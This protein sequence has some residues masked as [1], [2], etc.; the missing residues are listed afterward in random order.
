[1]D[2]ANAVRATNQEVGGRLLELTGASFT[3]PAVT[4]GTVVRVRRGRSWLAGP[5]ARALLI[6]RSGR[7][8]TLWVVTIHLGRA[9]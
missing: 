3:D 9:F 2:N 1:M 7:V 6:L 4:L 8:Y 5:D